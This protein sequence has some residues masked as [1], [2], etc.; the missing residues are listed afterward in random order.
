[1]GPAETFAHQVLSDDEA[2]A[3]DYAWRVLDALESVGITVEPRS[4]D[5]RPRALTGIRLLAEERDQARAEAE[6]TQRAYTSACA[7]LKAV[8]VG[9]GRR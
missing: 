5:P 8:T 1:M 7:A 3:I 9:G 2:K 6:R 4:T